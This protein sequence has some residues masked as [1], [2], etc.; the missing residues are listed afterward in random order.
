MRKER[1]EVKSEREEQKRG[2]SLNT[3]CDI[4]H[5][6][7]HPFRQNY[8]RRMKDITIIYDLFGCLNPSHC[9]ACTCLGSF[10]HTFI[11]PSVL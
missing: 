1:V 4:L 3:S 10:Y 9:Q 11:T 6:L 8:L 2:G 7:L 5:M